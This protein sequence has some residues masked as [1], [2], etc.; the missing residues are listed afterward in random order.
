MEKNVSKLELVSFKKNELFDKVIARGLM[1]AKGSLIIGTYNLQDIRIAVNES[2]KT[3]SL[4]DVVVS[5]LKRNVQI[6][7]VLAAFMLKSRFIQTLQEKCR[8]HENLRIRFCRRMHLKAVI[9]DLKYAYIGSAN[10]SGAGVGLKSLQ[11]RNF[12]LGFITRDT[13]L[14]ADVASMFMEIFTGKFCAKDR[15]YYF[16]NAHLQE[17]CKGILGHR[18]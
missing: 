5:L 15:C 8:N 2:Y 11:K 12:E 1:Q 9:V 7:M 17:P 3:V 6:L 10:L 18:F 16:E 13:E 4:S 14:I